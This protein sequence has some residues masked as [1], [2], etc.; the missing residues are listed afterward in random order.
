MYNFY[1]FCEDYSGYHLINKVSV[2]A[3]ARLHM[4]FMDLSGSLGRDFGSVGMALSEI[5]THLTMT[6][7][8][9]LTLTGCVPQ[10]GEK[11]LKHFCN[12]LNVSDK[13]HL[14][15]HSSIPEHIG[16]GSG[17]QLALSIGSALNSLY[18]LRLTIRD[19][20]TLSNRGLRSGI[21]IGVFERG[22]LIVDGG[23]GQQT[24]TPP[25]ISQLSIPDDWRF[26]LVFDTCGQG[27][28]G[29]QEI[30]AFKN[31][32]PF[33]KQEAARLCYLLLM[34][35]LPAIAENNL[36]LFGHVITQLQQSVGQHFA[37]AQGGIFASPDVAQVMLW[38]QQQGA[39]AIGQTS[40]GP[41]GFCAIRGTKT[42][43]ALMGE[44]KKRNR[45]TN[46]SFQ[47]TCVK[48]SAAKIQPY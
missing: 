44:L 20:A 8:K 46:L 36:E 30:Q 33:P 35:G 4:G 7:A 47:I 34:Q 17:T 5:N 37:N 26:L 16:L 42:A 21:G 10:Q 31:L 39:V 38:L 6:V 22:G 11:T 27:L 45:K 32:T 12:I 43:Q 41:T 18:H 3:P 24:Q 2:I 1:D 19:I 28:H 25:V 29:K 23:R 40:W 15:F 14:D 13:L 9:Q 48:N